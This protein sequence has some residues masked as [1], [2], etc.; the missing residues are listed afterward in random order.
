MLK[1]LCIWRRQ[2]ANKSS[3]SEAMQSEWDQQ[4][5]A[6]CTTCK[7]KKK[8]TDNW[9]HTDTEEYMYCQSAVNSPDTQES[10][11]QRNQN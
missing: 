8:A 2:T 1:L 9:T 11:D 4:W 6:A 10:E 5:L 3:K 7:K